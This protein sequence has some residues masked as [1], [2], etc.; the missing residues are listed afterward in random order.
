MNGPVRVQPRLSRGRLLPLA[1]TAALA[2]IGLVAA[3]GPASASSPAASAGSV[4]RQ[5][6]AFGFDTCVLPP[7]GTP[8]CWG[9]GYP[10]GEGQPTGTYTQIAVGGGGDC[11]LTAARAVSCWSLPVEGYESPPP[12]SGQY[13]QLSGGDDDDCALSTAGAMTCWGPFAVSAAGPFTQISDG[14]GGGCAIETS[15]DLYCFEYSAGS[16]YLSPP[17]GTYTTVAAGGD[18][19]CAIG[20]DQAISCWGDNT[21]GQADPP[22]GTYVAISAGTSFACALSTAGTVSCWGSNADDQL[23]APAG[24]FTAISAGAFHA[25]AIAADGYV[26]CWGYDNDGQLGAPPYLNPGPIPGGLQDFV[27]FADLGLPNVTATSD[28]DGSPPGTFRV[29]RGVIPPGLTLDPVYGL[30][31]GVITTA[32]N[33]PFTVSISNV[34]GA[35]SVHYDVQVRGYFLGF[36][37]PRPPARA[38][39][40]HRLSVQFRIGSDSGALVPAKWVP[41]MQLRVSISVHSNGARPFASA[42]CGY[43][44]AARVFECSLRL[45]RDLATGRK[46]RYYLTAY[47]QTGFGYLPCPSGKTRTDRNPMELWFS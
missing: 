13:T 29:T 31:Q 5:L 11:G 43:D 7:D 45:P 42:A 10:D 15:G 47:Q 35:R 22:S 14:S 4:V 41:G 21:Y 44:K 24:K 34:E 16:Y 17:S 28:P 37:D 2:V 46:H 32:G 26:R 8:Q 30:L 23:D 3:A 33:F 36:R 18:F 19:A 38:G 20:T 40:G 39:K 12:S 9:G 6:D 1:L 25:C 27:Y